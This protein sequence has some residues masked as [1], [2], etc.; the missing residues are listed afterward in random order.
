MNAGQAGEVRV[1]AQVT[2]MLGVP[3]PL[4]GIGNERDVLKQFASFQ[5]KSF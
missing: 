4:R 2:M 1:R 3:G 5:Q